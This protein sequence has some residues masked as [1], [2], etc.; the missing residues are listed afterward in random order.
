[1]KNLSFVNQNPDVRFDELYKV[2]G[3]LSSKNQKRNEAIEYYKKALKF[4]PNDFETLIEYGHLQEQTDPEQSHEAYTR[5]LD[6]F[7]KYSDSMRI[8]NEN[9][10][11]NEYVFRGKQL[12]I[13]IDSK[14]FELQ[15]ELYNNLGVIKNKLGRNL[16]AQTCFEEALRLANFYVENK[17]ENLKYK[18]LILFF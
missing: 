3:Y 1:M 13:K 4:D 14:I 6:L 7:E 12:R 9:D 18:V 17:E 15:P 8:E 5:A 10:G 16:E 2:L 11:E